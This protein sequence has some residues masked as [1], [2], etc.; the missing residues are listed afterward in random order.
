VGAEIHLGSGRPLDFNS[1]AV[2]KWWRSIDATMRQA[3]EHTEP[4]I[5]MVA[6]CGVFGQPVYYFIW[7]D[8]FPQAYES[9]SLRLFAALTAL[10][11]VFLPRW[12]ERLKRFARP[13]FYFGVF[14][15]LPFLFTYLLLRNDFST[16]WLMSGLAAMFLA[17]L[18][19]DWISL[20]AIWLTGTFVAYGLYGVTTDFAVAPDRYL[21]YLPIYL[22]VLVFGTIFNFKTE[23]L[24]RERRAAVEALRSEIAGE[25]RGPM[26]GMKTGVTGLKTYLPKLLEVYRE[27][28]AR[29]LG[30]AG[31]DRMPLSALAHAAD[32][33]EHELDHVTA[34]LDVLLRDPESAMLARES[35]ER[36]SMRACI[37]RTLASFPYTNG[38]ERA[39]IELIPEGD[40]NFLGSRPMVEHMLTSL[41]RQC[42]SNVA[43]A[44]GGKVTIRLVPGITQSRVVISD[45]GGGM[46]SATVARIFEGDPSGADHRVADP[47]GLAF[48]RKAAIAMGGRVICRSEIGEFT[49][50][51]IFLPAPSTQTAGRRETTAA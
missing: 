31:N 35:F 27:A 3:Y 44:G 22:F 23:M 5:P 7:N 48:S 21:P 51:D 13:L 45:T 42:L 19:L 30:T 11:F 17:I 4:N 10:P 28:R 8:L 38:W 40:F 16:I 43:D 32:R 46:P 9:L 6:L 36:L 50:F 33:I 26:R 1:G 29:D 20:T 12:P 49:A 47:I 25:L 14:A 41:L 15:N 39:A 18:A 24:R 34:V 2:A 37:S